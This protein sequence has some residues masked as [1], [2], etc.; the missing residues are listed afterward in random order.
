[1]TV[2]DYI[3]KQDNNERRFSF[4]VLPPLKGNGIEALF[5]TI[6]K[7]VDEISKSH[8]LVAKTQEQMDRVLSLLESEK[9]D[10]AELEKILRKKYESSLK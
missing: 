1:M 3:N 10:K 8:S 7:L 9:F 4:E 6:D 2:A 5:S